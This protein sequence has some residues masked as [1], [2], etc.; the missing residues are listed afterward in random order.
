MDSFSSLPLH[1]TLQKNLERNNLKTPTPVQAGS[2]PPAMEGRDVVATAQTGTGKTLAFALPI[3]Q[4]LIG[5]NG[6]GPIRAV[7]LSPTRELAI[8]I[9]ETFAKLTAG[10][11]IRTAVVVGGMSEFKQLKTLKRGVQVVIA[12]PGRLC[13]FLDRRLVRL[14]QVQHFVLDEADRM[15]DMGFLPSI[16]DIL[17]ATPAAKQ[18]LLFSATIE[19]SVA[20]LVESYVKDPVRVAIGATTK[21]ADFV[22]LHHYEVANAEKLSLLSHLLRAD[23][24]SFLVFARTKHGTDRL[25]DQLSDAGFKSTRIHGNRS[26]SQRNQALEGFKRGHYRVL[27]ATDVAARGIHVD[28]I[29]HVVNFD[30]PQVPEDFIHRV[31]RTGRAGSRGTAS[32]FSTRQ[33]RGEIRRI[34]KAI[35]LRLQSRD[36]P[37]LEERE[38]RRN[39]KFDAPVDFTPVADVQAEAREER[40]E[41][42]AESL[43]QERRSERQFNERQ[44][45]ERKYS[46][47]QFSDKRHSEKP[48][49]E[50]RQA[51]KPLWNQP[52]SQKKQPTARPFS[53]EEFRQQLLSEEASFREPK[54]KEVDERSFAERNFESK[55]KA[56]Q[57][58]V[59]KKAFKKASSN[60]SFKP[61][62][63]DKPKFGANAKFGDKPKFGEKPKFGSKFAKADGS[64]PFATAKKS[65]YAKPFAAKRS[66]FAHA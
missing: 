22:D 66:R 40:R 4:K 12:T 54:A 50:K 46:E 30:L 2:I 43:P 8:Q 47:R 62:F 3:I 48:R 27:V 39:R 58:V 14:D 65:P 10:T 25:A 53:S 7:I 29:A 21:T 17:S 42:R 26:Q 60:G 31:G 41:E 44:F 23:D 20:H 37:S 1:E 63:G 13:D 5:T 9:E 18:T 61:K 19:K 33:E 56:H 57:A 36:L 52:L 28:G 35:S 6:N 59:A 38:V 24:G 55:K 49:S 64:K 15:L 45:N 51:E 32:T 11:P 16:K 34:E